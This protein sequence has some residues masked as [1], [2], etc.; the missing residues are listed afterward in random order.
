MLLTQK[1]AIPFKESI[2]TLLKTINYPEFT[3]QEQY[4][5]RMAFYRAFEVEREYLEMIGQK[6]IRY[7][8]YILSLY[9]DVLLAESLIIEPEESDD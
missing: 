9:N 1:K 7:R 2:K 5:Q 3:P 6:E 4:L 8:K